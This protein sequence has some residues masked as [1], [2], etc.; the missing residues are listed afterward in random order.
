MQ[1]KAKENVH[2]Y[3]QEETLK[4]DH[5]HPQLRLFK[6]LIDHIRKTEAQIDSDLHILDIGCSY[7][8]LGRMLNL[9]KS[10]YTGIDF[11]VEYPDFI[12]HDINILPLPVEDKAYTIVIAGGSIEYSND[13]AALFK[14]VTRSMKQD[15]Y[16]IARYINRDSYLQRVLTILWSSKKGNPFMLPW[17]SIQDFEKE[18]ENHFTILKRFG[19]PFPTPLWQ[20]SWIS[21]LQSNPSLSSFLANSF[22]NV[23]SQIVWLTKVKK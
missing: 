1:N 20:P 5:Q 17:C 4:Y 9:D 11:A 23:C 15:A 7:G 16:F 13:R 2:N 22:T 18:L 14:D 3:W 21:K 10:A 8:T 6:K 12:R 19:I